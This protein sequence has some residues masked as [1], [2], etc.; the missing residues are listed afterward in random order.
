MAVTKQHQLRRCFQYIGEQKTR[1]PGALPGSQCWAQPSH[2]WAGGRGK[3]TWFQEQWS[4]YFAELGC[5]NSAAFLESY[6]GAAHAMQSRLST[7]RC[8]R[9]S[10]TMNSAL[11][12]R[13]VAGK[14]ARACLHT[15]L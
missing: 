3:D 14:R 15:E 7:A 12:V 2:T 13:V 9:A 1:E 8:A 6:E 10:S 11:S 4:H 5:R